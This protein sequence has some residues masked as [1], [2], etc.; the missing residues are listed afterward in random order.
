MSK[1]LLLG[2]FSPHLAPFCQVGLSEAQQRWHGLVVGKSGAGK[3]RFLQSVA[4]GYIQQSLS[5]Y[6]NRSLLLA[7]PDAGRSASRS[8][9]LDPQEPGGFWFLP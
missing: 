5:P 4:L 6:Q 7:W 3:S 2:T 1:K 9:L 8:G